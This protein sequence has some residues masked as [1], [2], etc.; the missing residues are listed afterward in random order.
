MK[1]VII[2]CEGPTEE[3]FVNRILVQ[4]LALKGVY[5]TASSCNGVS[6]YA[7]IRKDLNDWCRSDPE[8][9]V[10]TMLDY[11]ELP[12]DTPGMYEKQNSDFYERVGYIEKSIE[13]DLGVLNLHANLM[14]HEFEAILFSDP[15]QFSYCMDRAAVSQMI[16]V[17]EEF[18]NPEAIN[19]GNETA[20]SKRILKAWPEYSKV[21]DGYNIAAAIG[22]EKIRK[23]CRHFDEWLRWMEKQS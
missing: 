21:T 11:Y 2:Y 1:R 16:R 9:I 18:H 10:T 22:L 6:H 14:V 19:H 7:K 15:T 3:T 13:Q 17:K 8:R 12:S 4:H 5:V 23:E 20:P